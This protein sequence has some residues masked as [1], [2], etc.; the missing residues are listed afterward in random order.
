MRVRQLGPDQLLVEVEVVREPDDPG[1]GRRPWRVVAVAVATGALA[2]AAAVA[3]YSTELIPLSAMLGVVA[4]TAAHQLQPVDDHTKEL[5]LEREELGPEHVHL[6]R[7][8]IRGGTIRVDDVA[9]GRLRVDA[10]SVEI[11]GQLRVLDEPFDPQVIELLRNAIAHSESIRDA[12]SGPE[13]VP[14]ALAA[15]RS[16]PVLRDGAPPTSRGLS[17]GGPTLGHS[18]G[19]PTQGPGSDG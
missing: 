2:L 19:G 5:D 1:F 4:L 3:A 16:A 17:S 13:A 9:V 8:E 11:D 12:R 14:T 6:L 10:G 15:L 7:I 18:S